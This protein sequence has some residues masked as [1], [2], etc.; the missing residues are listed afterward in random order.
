MH[1]IVVLLKARIAE[2]GHSI[3]QGIKPLESRHPD[4]LHSHHFLMGTARKNL[5]ASIRFG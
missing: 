1:P 5:P 2:A 3:V 4:I